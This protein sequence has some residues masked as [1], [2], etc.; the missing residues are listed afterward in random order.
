MSKGKKAGKRPWL[1]YFFATVLALA[2]GG[3]IA[4][5]GHGIYYGWL[6]P[7]WTGLTDA[8]ASVV[9]QVIF[10]LVGAWAAVLV[11]LLFSE[12]LQTVEEAARRVEAMCVQMEEQ[13][14]VASAQSA[15]QFESITRIQVMSLGY[16]MDPRQLDALVSNEAR[17]AFIKNSWDNAK[18]KIDAAI[19][20]Q[21]GQRRASIADQ[22]LRS[23]DWWAKL[24]T[25]QVLGEYYDD[26]KTISDKRN[27]QRPEPADLHIV[28][29]AVRRI[30]SFEPVAV[31]AAVNAAAVAPAAIP[32]AMIIVPPTE[33]GRE[34]PQ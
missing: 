26:F 22:N 28:N 4:A 34:L 32:P 18:R 9:T 10:F 30:S 25:F 23:A 11:P 27:K 29:E 14:K 31:Q 5:A 16:L 1:L 24:Q 8:Q 20:L 13:M 12:Q 6:E 15:E 7:Y 2:T 21:N 33:N 19:A 3:L 17:L